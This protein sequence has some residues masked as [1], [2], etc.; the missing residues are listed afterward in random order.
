ME[1]FLKVCGGN[2]GCTIK[3]TGENAMT[4]IGRKE[5]TAVVK[6]DYKVFG[7]FIYTSRETSRC[8]AVH[9]DIVCPI[10]HFVVTNVAEIIIFL[11]A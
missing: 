11:S 1:L 8:G 4:C 6:S 9:S 7:L 10:T 2:V 5:K 3:K